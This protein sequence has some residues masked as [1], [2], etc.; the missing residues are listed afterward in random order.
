MQTAQRGIDPAVVE[1]LLD[2]PFRFKFFQAVRVLDTWFRR[3]DEPES[4]ER[5]DAGIVFRNSLALTF[6]PSEIEH[7]LS[8][9]DAGEVIVGSD[10]VRV[11]LAQRKVERIELTPAFFGLLGGQGALPLRY[12]EQL[13]ARAQI[14]R[15]HAARAFFDVF[16]SRATA[17][18]YAAWKNT[19]Y[20]STMSSIA[21]S[22]I[23][24]SCWRWPV[25]PTQP[26]AQT[27]KKGPAP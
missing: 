27:C 17:L 5:R 22:A 13:I 20:R 8:Y 4:D 19:G 11:A 6:P 26:R 12:T 9:D 15:D 2:Q 23:C 7:A 24:R 1:R 25:C 21:M 10:A 16:S 14:Q 3:Q 18:F